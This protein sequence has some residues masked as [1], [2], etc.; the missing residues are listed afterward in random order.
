MAL[1]RSHENRGCVARARATETRRGFPPPPWGLP[2][3]PEGHLGLRD[4]STMRTTVE[5]IGGGCDGSTVTGNWGS[6]RRWL[7]RFYCKLRCNWQLGV[8]AAVAMRNSH[9]WGKVAR[10]RGN[11]I[12]SATRYF[13][14]KSN[15]Q[16]GVSEWPF[17]RF[18]WV[19]H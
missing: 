16:Q 14:S 12:L 3:A 9:R 1:P 13:R 5:C 2:L 19:N 8:A 10:K 17:F 7:R 4:S 18:G 11:E 15:E 6:Y